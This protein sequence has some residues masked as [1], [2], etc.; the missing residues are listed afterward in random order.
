MHCIQHM[1]CYPSSPKFRT[2]K[3][4]E[5]RKI[6]LFSMTGLL[7]KIRNPSIFYDQ[8][9]PENQEFR[10]FHE[11]FHEILERDEEKKLYFLGNFRAFPLIFSKWILKIILKLHLTLQ[12]VSTDEL[13][14]S[15]TLSWSS[16]FQKSYRKDHDFL[17][18]T[19]FPHQLGVIL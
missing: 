2:P 19:K 3:N 18:N 4:Q 16:F 6:L 10:I 5:F 8:P 1:I 11:I 9:S 15:K 14:L 12:Y 13:R 7:L 17:E